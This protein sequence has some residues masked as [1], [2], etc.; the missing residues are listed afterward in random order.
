MFA[1][2][3]EM[4]FG[5][6]HQE[7]GARLAAAWKFP[8]ATASAIRWHHQPNEAPE[9]HRVLAHHIYLSDTLCC[10]AKIGCP[11]TCSQQQVTDEQ[12]AEAG[13]T[14]EIADATVVKL[15]LLLRLFMT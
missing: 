11:L 6:T 9:D 4:V 10:L 3:E 8:D 15:P 2:V 12:L 7:L 5:F 1:P 14:R 13:I